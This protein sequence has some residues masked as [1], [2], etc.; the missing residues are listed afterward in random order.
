MWY[1]QQRVMCVTSQ[2]IKEDEDKIGEVVEGNSSSK[3]DTF[4]YMLCLKS[5][6]G[7]AVTIAVVIAINI[8]TLASCVYRYR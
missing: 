3:L 8:Y 7:G 5:D 4:V 2:H 1:G 6:E